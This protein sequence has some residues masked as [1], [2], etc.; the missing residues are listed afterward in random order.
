MTFT[1]FFDEASGFQGPCVE[2]EWKNH[3]KSFV[4]TQMAQFELRAG[5]TVEKAKVKAAA[6]GVKA[7]MAAEK[8]KK[9]EK[10]RKIIEV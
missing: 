1:T 7:A 9:P 8:V 10:K 6:E 2:A 3:S 4:E 5:K